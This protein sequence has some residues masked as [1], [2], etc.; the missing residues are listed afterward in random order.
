M[1]GRQPVPLRPKAWTLLYHLAQRPGLLVTKEELHKA[2]WG[3]IVVSDDTVTR[4]VAELRRAL[5]DDAREPRVIETVHR[6]GFR[7][8]ASTP[9]APAAAESG[10]EPASR[11]EATDLIGRDAELRTLW[12]HFRQAQGGRRQV[13]FVQGEAGIGKSALVESF[14][15]AVAAD[16]RSRADRD[17]PERRAVRPAR[18]VHAGPGGARAAEPGT[19]RAGPAVGDAIGRSELAGSVPGAP[20]PDQRRAAATLARR[21]HAPPDAP[22]VLRPRRGPRGRAPPDHR[23]RGSPL[24][25]PGHG[26]PGLGARPA[27]GDGAPDARGHAS[28]G[29]GR[30]ARPPHPAGPHAAAR[31]PPVRGD[32]PR[33]PDPAGRGG[34]PAA[35]VRGRAGGRRGRERRPRTHR[36]QCP[37][38]DPA[39]RSPP[40]RAACSWSRR[41]RGG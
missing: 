18:A 12:G 5:S 7:F 15:K 24:E 22:G 23:A 26:G 4:T 29:A 1:A 33:V 38:H 31:A 35:A 34:L 13:V 20:G 10:A 36:R 37:L 3:D 21:H 16:A 28:A 25:R 41:A 6:R 17:R 14:V 8:I 2:V 32:R 9:P 19:V 30:G 11:P 39:R 27:D 40:R